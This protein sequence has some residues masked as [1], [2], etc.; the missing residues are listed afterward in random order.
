MTTIPAIHYPSSAIHIHR[1]RKTPMTTPAIRRA[2][3]SI[4]LVL[5]G[6]AI[7]VWG[8]AHLGS[9]AIVIA[10]VLLIVLGSRLLRPISHGILR[11]LDAKDV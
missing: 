5:S 3:I 9:P 6:T 8:G 11:W 4:L 7:A 1:G 10:G 2:L